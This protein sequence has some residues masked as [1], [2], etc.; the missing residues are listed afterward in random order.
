MTV[1]EQIE[2]LFE[3]QKLLIESIM[4]IQLDI[5]LRP[6]TVSLMY[7][8]QVSKQK[9][10]DMKFMM[11]ASIRCQPLVREKAIATRRE[12]MQMLKWAKDVKSVLTRDQWTK[13]KH[14]LGNC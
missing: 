12:N 5:N 10:K 3:S 11:G 13:C 6:S 9:G 7:S 2:Y 14:S 1:E 4:T 8:D